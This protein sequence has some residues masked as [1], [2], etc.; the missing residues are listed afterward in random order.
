MKLFG[1][2]TKAVNLNAITITPLVLGTA[3]EYVVWADKEVQVD[4]EAAAPHVI[5][6]GEVGPAVQL[7]GSTGELTEYITPAYKA[8]FHFST[9]D[10]A[11]Q[12][13]VFSLFPVFNSLSIGWDADVD[14]LIEI[15]F[16]ILDTNWDFRE[17]IMDLLANKT[18][19][20]DPNIS[21]VD[22]KRSLVR[23]PLQV[24][25]D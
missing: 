10:V 21:N 11:P 5:A 9:V 25:E 3:V 1:S 4:I 13:K 18:R 15:D 12:T 7:L 16:T 2:R 22:G 6:I 23:A 24:A 20:E 19:V 17:E 14:A 8:L